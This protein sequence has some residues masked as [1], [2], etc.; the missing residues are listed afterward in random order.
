M[1]IA[2]D[3]VKRVFT[4]PQPANLSP[5]YFVKLMLENAA[6]KPVSANFY[7]LSTQG[8]T[9]DHPREGSDWYYTPTKQFAD[10]KALNTL[11]AVALKISAK[12]EILNRAERVISPPSP[13]RSGGEGRGEVVPRAQGEHQ[14]RVTIQNPTKSLAFFIHLKVNSSK[15]GEEILPVIWEDNYF[16]L[17]PGEKREVTATYDLPQAAKPVVEVEGWNIKPAT[18]TQ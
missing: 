2:S 6:G 18:I 16:S 1:D 12:S 7:W 17:L 11:P 9:L 3:G 15:D 10:F 4:L 14:T 13:P 5:T 8:D